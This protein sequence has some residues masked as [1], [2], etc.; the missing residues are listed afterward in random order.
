M[1]LEKICYILGQMEIN[2]A[3]LYIDAIHRLPSNRHGP[4]PVI[5]KFRSKL[6]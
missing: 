4:R 3:N 2:V 6:D 5:V 1:L